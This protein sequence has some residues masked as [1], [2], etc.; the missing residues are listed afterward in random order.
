MAVGVSASSAPS[1]T[2]RYPVA[3][4]HKPFRE[5]F[6]TLP[7][8]RVRRRTVELAEPG[9]DATAAAAQIGA[10]SERPVRVVVTGAAGYV[11]S[12]LVPELLRRGHTVV[13]TRTGADPPA[14]SWA[15]RV[16]WRRM[17]VL[18]LRETVLAL[19]GSTPWST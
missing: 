8:C 14:V 10:E 1:L 16:E 12:R 13:A 6:G 4:D 9:P 7:A 18:N 2:L 15:E 11:G 3:L 19:A 17:D 5:S